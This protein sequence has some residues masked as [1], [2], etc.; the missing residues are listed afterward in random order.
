MLELVRRVVRSEL[1]RTR[2]SALAVVTAVH[3]HTAE[4]DENN[5]EVDVKLKHDDLELKRVPVSVPHAGAAAPARVGDLV[6]VQPL[7][8]ELQQSLVTGR[9]Y[10]VDDRPPLHQED[11]VL[12]EHRVADGTLNH[13][14]FAQDGTI[15]LQRDV[16]KPEDNSEAKTTLRID[17]ASGDVK[18]TA[19]DAI[20]IELVNDGEIRITADG[21]PV[22]IACDKLTV[23]GE[24]LVKGNSEVDGELKVV[25]S[26]KTTTI[27]GGE[28]SAS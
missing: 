13:L 15:V 21:K 17:G 12:L 26:G 19:G 23:D 20:V 8:G 16:T 25:T 5:Y 6:L 24:L 10:H 14:R 3:A 7:D 27:K 11:E 28:I 1:A 22:G 18:L 4:D 9:F 2:T